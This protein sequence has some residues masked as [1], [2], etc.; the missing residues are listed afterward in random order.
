MSHAAHGEG[1]EY[2]ENNANPVL[3]AIIGRRSIRRYLDVPVEWDKVGSIC[4]AGMMAPSAGNLQVWKFAVVRDV[5]KR[6][7]ISEA[8]LQQYWME[9]APVHI[10]IFAELTKME[11]YYGIRGTRLY[12]IQDCAM[13]GLNMM[14][15]ANSMGLGSCFVSAFDEEAMSRIFKLPETVRAQGVLTIGYSDDHPT[16]PLRYRFENVVGL[17]NYGTGMNQRGRIADPAAAVQT[18]RYAQRGQGYVKDA[19]SDVSKAVAHKNKK[20]FEKLR[21]RGKKVKEQLEKNAKKEKHP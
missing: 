15:A 3:N 7:L 12:S 9:Q 4:Y 13:A 18:Y 8:C 11:R 5:N 6:R 17:E 21:A 19:I 14:L 2:E 16:P 20:F 10:V 1:N